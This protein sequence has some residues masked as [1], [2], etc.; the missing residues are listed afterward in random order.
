MAAIGFPGLRK[1]ANRVAA[2][3]AQNAGQRLTNLE[4]SVASLVANGGGGGVTPP[5][6]TPPTQGTGG[7]SDTANNQTTN[8]LTINFAQLTALPADW[9][10]PTGHST[11]DGNGLTV[12]SVGADGWIH[13]VV[14]PAIPY[15]NGL[16]LI[17]EFRTSFEFGA[18][19]FIGKGGTWG[20]F[21]KADAFVITTAGTNA[22]VHNGNSVLGTA[23]VA[24]AP[25]YTKLT[26]EFGNTNVRVLLESETAPG[27]FSSRYD[28]SHPIPAEMFE[29][30]NAVVS[31]FSG[32]M[33]LRSLVSESTIA[34][35]VSGGI[36][37]R[38][39]PATFF[40]YNGSAL[41]IDNYDTVDMPLVGQTLATIGGNVIRWPGGDESN[42]WNVSG[43]IQNSEQIVPTWEQ[44]FHGL[45]LPIWIAYQTGEQTATYANFKRMVDAAGISSVAWVV[46]CTTS[47]P[48]E[49]VTK[50]Q[51][52][53]AAGLPVEFLELGNE[54]YFNLPYYTGNGAD[55]PLRGHI[56]ADDYAI[57][58]RDNYVP[59]LRAA[60]PD[61]PIGVPVI[62]M[63]ATSGW[64]EANWSSSI[65]NTG[66]WALIDFIAVHP[67][68]NINDIGL[69]K[70]AVGS[71]DRAGT[72]GRRAY[73]ELKKVLRRN[74]LS[75]FGENAKIL[76]TEFNVLED[77]SQTG[78][79]MLGQSWLHGLIQTMKVLV[80]LSDP[81]ID[82]ALV[83]SQ[84]GNAQWSGMTN[85]NGLNVD[86]AK[87]GVDNNP[88]SDGISPPFSPTLSGWCMGTAQR[89][90]L[91]GGGQGTLLVNERGYVAWR[92]DNGSRDA[93]ILVN[94]TDAANTFTPPTN[95]T[96]NYETW[97]T[98]P[99][100]DALNIPN[101]LPQS[102]TGS[103]PQ[104]GSVDVPAFSM[105]VLDATSNAPPDTTP[106][107]VSITDIN[108]QA[109]NAFTLTAQSIVT[110]EI[111][112]SDAATLI[113]RAS[114]VGG[115]EAVFSNGSIQPLNFVSANESTNAQ[116]ITGQFS[117][118]LRAVSNQ[119]IQL[120]AKSTITD[121]SQNNIAR[122]Q[123][124]SITVNIAN[125]PTP[126]FTEDYD[127][128]VLT[129][130]PAGWQFT[131]SQVTFSSQGMRIAPTSQ[132]QEWGNRAVRSDEINYTDGTTVEIDLVIPSSLSAF[133]LGDTKANGGWGDFT[134]DDCLMWQGTD[135]KLIYGASENIP[136]GSGEWIVGTTYRVRF[137][138]EGTASIVTYFKDTG[139]G[140][141][142]FKQGNA[143]HPAVL[144][145]SPTYVLLDAAYSFE[146]FIKRVAINEV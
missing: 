70:A 84:I 46:N 36:S 51:N 138:R 71:F 39:V 38:T 29:G 119:S 30:I 139:S 102:T 43:L 117:I 64:R 67:Y 1:L 116:S 23:T 10:E 5:V 37:E 66:L 48:A 82:M 101:D 72:A 132:T 75:L 17:A 78:V 28:Q 61:L 97:N 122:Q 22:E 73:D 123:I 118:D 104:S 4:G 108:G 106:P 100:A 129:N 2:I 69:D 127:F 59:A 58:M 74:S 83:H 103:I 56:T 112:A 88:F 33:V 40:G 76:V 124:G 135:G 85:A 90:V 81:R 52:I 11:V 143:T 115:I 26:L 92:V 47:T 146:V 9:N 25:G 50:L 62:P 128:T 8:D 91:S 24:A 113:N 41:D 131:D 21:Q 125:N 142:Q 6:V 93:I 134:D 32:D 136:D 89:R 80:M 94:A 130:L 45:A 20:T 14:S 144:N 86:P 19:G 120:F 49:E 7:T 12:D 54:L 34:P 13:N 3:E 141:V 31:P 65:I 111:V 140:F 77:Q 107:T 145:T 53:L 99:W 44:H 133:G 110:V 137:K 63:D 42:F 98:N 57:D 60:F 79:V 68:F 109:T 95:A 114:F 96:W 27:V 55:K 105:I 18:M 16:R 15:A 126:S 121:T 87:R 35:P